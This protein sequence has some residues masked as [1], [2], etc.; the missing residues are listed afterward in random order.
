[1]GVFE[2]VPPSDA[3][4]SAYEELYR[5]GITNG[6]T[7]CGSGLRYCPDDS[8]TR[9]HAAVFLNRTF[10][11]PPVPTERV[12]DFC[13][14]TRGSYDLPNGRRVRDED[15]IC[16][17][18]ATNQFK[19]FFN[20][21]INELD[22]DIDALTILSDEAFLFSLQSS[23]TL[24]GN[25]SVRDEDIVRFENGAFSLEID[26]STYPNLSI[27]NID[28]DAL[29]YLS[30]SRIYMSTDS[31]ED[32]GLSAEV[33]DQD[34]FRF[35][36]STGNTYPF[37]TGNQIGMTVGVNGISIA[38]YD[39]DASEI[40]MTLDQSFCLDGANAEICGSDGDIVKFTGSTGSATSGDFGA[41]LCFNASLHEDLKNENLNA[42]HVEN[43]DCELP[44]ALPL[45]PDD[46]PPPAPDY[47][48]HVDPGTLN[49]AAVANTQNPLAQTIHILNNGVGEDSMDWSA[50]ADSSWLTF[51]QSSGITPVIVEMTADIAGL[52][53]GVYS[54]TITISSPQTP[55]TIQSVYVVLDVG[56][57]PSTIP[58]TAT[59]D[60]G[61]TS[62]QID[63]NSTND[64]DVVEY[65]VTRAISGTTTFATVGITADT[66]YFDEDLAL[67][68]ESTYCYQ[69]EALHADGTVAI[70]SNTTC[71]M[72]HLL[73]LWA[74]GN[75]VMP[76]ET[77][78]VRIGIAN[79]HGLQIET[80]DIWLEYDASVI[81]Y[82]SIAETELTQDYV[83]L[84]N[85]DTLPGTTNRLKVGLGVFG[86]PIPVLY[87]D[88]ALF[89]ITFQAIGN[90]GDNTPLDL[91]EFITG[92]GGSSVYSPDDLFNPIPLELVDG[93]MQINGNGGYVRGDINGDG[94]VQFNDAAIAAH[95]Y[96]GDITPTPEQFLA[97]DV[98]TDNQ[99]DMEDVTM[100]R[101]FAVFNE[102]PDTNN[103]TAVSSMNTPTTPITV[104]ITNVSGLPGEKV[105][106]SVNVINLSGMA[107]G[108]IALA[109]DT[110]LIAEID[111][112][113]V[114][115]LADDFD[116]EYEDDG[117]GLLT[118]GFVG[119]APLSGDGTLLTIALILAD[120][121][122]GGDSAPLALADARFNDEYGRDFE[123]SALQQSITTQS[124]TLT[125]ASQPEVS[126]SA[127]TLRFYQSAQDISGVRDMVIS[128]L[129]TGSL[130]W[131][132][133]HSIPWLSL[134][135]V[136]GIAPDIIQAQVNASGISP[137]IYE[138][139]IV[140]TNDDNPEDI[141]YIRVI[142]NVEA[143]KVYLP[144]VVRQQINQKL[145]FYKKPN[146]FIQRSK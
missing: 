146:F 52:S 27:D 17:Y 138:E 57:A 116:L 108:T 73:E 130:H 110:S 109:Y 135:T 123:Y 97:G 124:G 117:Q 47:I 13:F 7:G 129:G 120:G 80:S 95:I 107:G 11:T 20:G 22:G 16:Y 9:A 114:D 144:I 84:S 79:A 34:I 41:T 134:D 30:G 90:D 142:L 12:G 19:M 76:G 50:S 23:D 37:F 28:V 42:L 55:Y 51:A 72:I 40:Y 132:A 93:I 33:E 99:I 91:R 118:I 36:E 128:N 32:V 133:V 54:D 88:G 4:A 87:N 21:S 45:A 62:I 43:L 14:S 126:V 53:A 65:N 94:A 31:S 26:S 85:V 70:T 102:W 143:R 35:R 38:S 111:D 77:G 131:T 86:G 5:L 56:E 113:A 100:I 83:W 10:I 101:Q 82:I 8:L 64:P 25:I 98:N 48:L 59:A 63:W 122:I 15:I 139:I 104:S 3:K 39:T 136:T 66:V 2:D 29:A 121:A 96:L 49:F 115:D 127:T 67:I 141:V 61:H 44:D 74:S 69:I 89:E 137:G 105:Y 24:P 119:D 1:M 106:A 6:A 71:A 46:D 68:P 145:G 125:I 58:V 18:Q 75:T 140:L 103:L 81:Q 60:S 78:V 92:V 112:V